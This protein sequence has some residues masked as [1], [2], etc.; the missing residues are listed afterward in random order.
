M[1]ILVCLKGGFQTGGRKDI[2][3]ENVAC[4]GG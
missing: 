3:Q 4:A 2:L 1:K